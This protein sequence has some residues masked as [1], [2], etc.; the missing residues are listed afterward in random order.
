M[1]QKAS[2]AHSL[3]FKKLLVSFLISV[4]IFFLIELLLSFCLMKVP[5]FERYFTLASW[6][7]TVLLAFVF[8]LIAKGEKGRS[9]V[10]ALILSS[11]F[12]LISLAIGLMIHPGTA[13]VWPMIIRHLSLVVMTLALTFLYSVTG[14]KKPKKA[15]FKKDFK[16]K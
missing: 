5:K 16:K 13:P 9:I 10:Y 6:I 1:N 2:P 8:S 12:A 4:G 7:T 11:A 14:S 3:F 15:K